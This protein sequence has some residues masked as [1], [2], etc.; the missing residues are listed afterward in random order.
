LTAN[1]F[2]TSQSFNCFGVPMRPAG[3]NIA[4]VYEEI[5][6]STVYPVTAYQ[7]KE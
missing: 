5:D 3:E 1:Q 4:V 2:L 7:V 6:D